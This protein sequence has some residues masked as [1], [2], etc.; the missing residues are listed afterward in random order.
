MKSTLDNFTQKVT[1]NFK[2][3]KHGLM[4]G[5][6][7]CL[8]DVYV[9]RPLFPR[10]VIEKFVSTLYKNVKTFLFH[11]MFSPRNKSTIP[12]SFSVHKMLFSNISNE[13]RGANPATVQQN[14][15]C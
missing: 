2:H 12:N 11:F 7:V 6:Q 8:R 3:K 4:N 10:A 9:K 14:L 1:W 13:F 15:C 5:Y